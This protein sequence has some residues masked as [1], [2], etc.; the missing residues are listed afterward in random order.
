M[1]ERF[2]DRARKAM[3]LANTFAQRFNHEYL[4]T[5]HILVGVL[6]VESSIAEA[7]LENLKIPKKVLVDKINN[8]LQAQPDK[9]VYIS[10]LPMTPRGKKIIEFAMEEAQKLN[11]NWVGTEHLLLGCMRE[12]EGIAHTVLT[13]AGLTYTK[14]HEETLKVLKI[15]EV[16]QLRKL[17]VTT[18]EKLVSVA[19]RLR[20]LQ[21]Q[22]K[23]VTTEMDATLAELLSMV[24]EP[25]LA[26]F[27]T[28][29]EVEVRAMVDAM[30]PKEENA[31]T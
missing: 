7:I 15:V 9:G 18:T 28:T 16:D 17:N 4:G 26:E 8:L 11:H 29:V 10:K 30:E 3:Q 22:M 24:P 31:Q 20:L 19:A 12:T 14:I 2:T 25:K 1:F 5:E 13:E 6:K 21:L 27:N 23:H